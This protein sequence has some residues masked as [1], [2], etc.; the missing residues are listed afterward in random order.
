MKLWKRIL[1]GVLA[2]I[3][4]AAV[5]IWILFKVSGKAKLPIEAMTGPVR[6]L[7]DPNPP[8]VPTIASAH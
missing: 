6:A 8:L 7:P 5:G 3:V 2:A 1:I 4:V